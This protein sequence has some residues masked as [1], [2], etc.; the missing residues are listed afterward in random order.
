M[1]GAALDIDTPRPGVVRLRLDRPTRRNAL[2]RPLVEAL[3]GALDAVEARAVV[4][5]S[6]DP[7]VFCGG[8]DLDLEDAERAALSERL[9]ALY[10]R[11][12]AADVPL[13][14]AVGG[15]A[16]GGGAQLAAARDARVARPPARPRVPGPGHRPRGGAR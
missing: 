11:M 10:E 16:G 5:G 6:T 4:L 9:Y 1:A 3:H 14:A 12:L 15:A 7:S 13:I 8:A 2:D